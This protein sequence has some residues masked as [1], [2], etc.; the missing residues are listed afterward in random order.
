MAPQGA[1]VDL[2]TFT[3]VGTIIAVLG[4]VII[5]VAFL[6]VPKA[7]AEPKPDPLKQIEQWLWPPRNKPPV[8]VPTP[9]PAPAPVPPPEVLEAIPDPPPVV[10]PPPAPVPAPPKIEAPPP[11]IEK[12]APLPKRPRIRPKPKPPA[13]PRKPDQQAPAPRGISAADCARL[14]N[15]V[16]TYGAGMVEMG[17]RMR[18]YSSAQIAYAK[19]A[20]GVR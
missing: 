1:S 20:C 10:E 19:R 14:R 11:K 12:E 16:A 2:W 7:R 18:G 9:R 6:S 5:L 17:A 15:A 8:P 3:V 4:L 13:Q